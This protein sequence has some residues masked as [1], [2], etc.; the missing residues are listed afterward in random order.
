MSSAIKGSWVLQHFEC[1]R[2]LTYPYSSS[3]PDKSLN[4]DNL[5][6]QL[7]HVDITKWHRLGEALGVPKRRLNDITYHHSADP[8]QC[9]VE[10]LDQWLRSRTRPTWREVADALTQIHESEL[11]NSLREVYTTGE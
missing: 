1:G 8:E 7:Q 3:L 9:K 5:L 11:A 10:V 4:L 2:I 6:I